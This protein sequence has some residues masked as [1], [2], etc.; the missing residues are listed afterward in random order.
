MVGTDG[1]EAG[2]EPW[3]PV[4][5]FFLANVLFGAGLFAHAFLYNFYLDGLGL[6]ESVMGG[7]AAALTAGGLVAL[8]PAGAIADR[9]GAG[10][11]YLTAGV[12]SVAG[13]V[14]GALVTGPTQIYA[15]AFLSGGGVAMWRVASG[16]IMM[17]LTRGGMRSRAFSW[18]V[19]LLLGSGAAWIALSGQVPG[20]IESSFGL[21]GFLGIRW[22]LLVGAVGTGAGVLVFGLVAGRLTR[23]QVAREGSGS[24]QAAAREVFDIPRS[25]MVLAGLVALWMTAGGLVIPFFNVYFLRTHGLSVSQIGIAL[26]ASQAVAA[27]LILGSGELA[28]RSGAAKILALWSLSFGPLLLALAW[29]PGLATAM[30]L[31]LAQGLVPPAT[32]PLIDQLLLERAPEE[33]RGAVSSWRNGA[34]DLSGFVGAALG[35]YILQTASFPVLFVVA[36]GLAL[37]GAAALLLGLRVTAGGPLGPKGGGI[38]DTVR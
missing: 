1:S 36:G 35:G 18:N 22:A 4:L 28:A 21:G 8:L 37:V 33:R 5:L 27:V 26:A 6:G 9:L 20:W 34:T 30:T 3:G 19:A 2:R 13:Q 11:A 24:M 7:A 17:G 31:Y 29:A 32:N 38:L 16:P 10:R 25:L 15:A 23:A 12:L 14:S